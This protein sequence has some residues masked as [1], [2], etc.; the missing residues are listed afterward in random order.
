MACD[1]NKIAKFTQE[2]Q[3]LVAMCVDHYT[4]D[5]VNFVS[6]N[7][8]VGNIET[9]IRNRIQNDIL[10][11][12]EFNHRTYRKY[13]NDIFEVIEVILDQTL[14][15]GW[16]DNEFFNRFVDVHRVDLGDTNEF[17]C[18]DNTLL[19]VSRF[20]GNHWDT[21]RE[22]FDLGRNFPVATSWY[23]VHFYNDFERF[24]KNID[25]FSK[26]LSKARKS[27]LQS[28]QNGIYVAFSNMGEVLPEGFVGHGTLATDTEKEQLL[29]LIERVETATGHRAVIVGANAA[30]RKLQGNIES[31]WISE[32]AKSERQRNGIISMWEG[33]EL[34]PLPQ[35]FKAGTFEFE[36]STTRLLIVSSE[37]KPIKFV[38]EG[39]S[40]MKEISENTKNMDQ[41]LESQ[42][43]VKAGTAVVA[44]EIFG[45][46]ELA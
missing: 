11:G 30:L 20:S 12:A 41:T 39:N 16:S 34:L 45:E 33:Y 17:Y 10:G 28:F 4:G 42:I 43:Q 15:E 26:M 14:P 2:K 24:M 32:D 23:E 25:S 21:M 19:T 22:R 3:E 40:R 46:W 7:V 35:V 1:M 27:F 31:D 8:D 29:D 9:E 6:S 36:L 37:S 44:D 13:K 38:Y 5:L 18:E